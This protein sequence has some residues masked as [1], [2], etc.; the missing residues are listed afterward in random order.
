[1]RNQLIIFFLLSYTLCFGASSPSK[2]GNK[3]SFTGP[4]RRWLEGEM[5]SYPSKDGDIFAQNFSRYLYEVDQPYE[6]GNISYFS[7]PI[8]EETKKI[9][10]P[11]EVQNAFEKMFDIKPFSLSSHRGKSNQWMLEGEYKKH[12]RF[13]RLIITKHSTRFSFT[14]A[15]LRRPYLE[16]TDMSSLWIQDKIIE[17]EEK[18]IKGE[19]SRKTSFFNLFPKAYAA[20]GAPNANLGTEYPCEGPSPLPT[21]SAATCPPSTSCP[22]FTPATAAAH[23]ACIQAIADC[24]TEQLLEAQKAIDARVHSIQTDLNC[25]SQWWSSKLDEHSY[26]WGDKVDRGLDLMEKVLSPLGIAGLAAGGVVGATVASMGMNLA[27]SGIQ[28]GAEALW[29]IVSG[30]AAEEKHQEI[31]KLFMENKDKWDAMNEEAMALASKIDT[32]VDLLEF[33]QLSGKPLEKIILESKAKAVELETKVEDAKDSYKTLR[34]E[35]RGETAACVEEAKEEY[36]SLKIEL[37]ELQREIEKV[38]KVQLDHGSFDQMCLKLSQNLESLLQM[39]GDLQN[40]RI[41]MLKSFDH[42]QVEEGRRREE[43]REAGRDLQLEDAKKSYKEEMQRAKDSLLKGIKTSNIESALLKATEACYQDH[44]KKNGWHNIICRVPILAPLPVIGGFAGEEDAGI[45]SACYYYKKK[46]SGVDEKKNYLSKIATGELGNLTPQKRRDLI[47]ADRIYEGLVGTY[48]SDKEAAE[49][50]YQQKTK[51]KDYLH[52][53]EETSRAKSEALHNWMMSLRAEQACSNVPNNCDEKEIDDMFTPI[54]SGD[55]QYNN[56]IIKKV[57]VDGKAEVQCE[58]KHEG[59]NCSCSK[60]K[61]SAYFKCRQTKAE[62]DANKQS[63]TCYNLPYCPPKDNGDT[64]HCES[65]CPRVIPE[66]TYSET[67]T[68]KGQK[69]VN[70]ICKEQFRNCAEE[71]LQTGCEI[72]FTKRCTGSDEFCETMT[73]KCREQSM[74]RAKFRFEKLRSQ[75]DLIK[76]GACKEALR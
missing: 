38:E 63:L 2:M 18:I 54:G 11:K 34:D 30:A 40:A 15:Y 70:K 47:H 25:Q 26:F 7:I 51:M 12:G 35:F 37:M 28:A 61:K 49:R 73:K 60:I 42:F 9:N 65:F 72:H 27:I 45:E 53:N 17:R 5:R 4:D 19:A 75:S 48:Y 29:R 68:C 76:K 59:F 23:N 56:E 31:L 6:L 8:T 20:S 41:M 66:C 44:I 43:L 46:C 52:F 22:P 55:N 16:S 64:S 74:N 71:N 67:D 3:L 33:V 1:M 58:C 21:T 50:D 32:A 14:I 36:N 24:R 57:N 13:I 62:C 10:S 39:E 69:T